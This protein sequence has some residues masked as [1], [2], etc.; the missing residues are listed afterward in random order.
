MKL[1]LKPKWNW[2]LK[3]MM[4]PKGESKR[5]ESIILQKPCST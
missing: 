3:P 1:K 5:S 4:K 2:K